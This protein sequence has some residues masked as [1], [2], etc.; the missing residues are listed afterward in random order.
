MPALT[1]QFHYNDTSFG[2]SNDFSKII[3]IL[4][5]QLPFHCHY[6]YGICTNAVLNST[7]LVQHSINNR[8][9][10]EN[11]QIKTVQRFGHTIGAPIEKVR[12]I[13]INLSGQLL[14]SGNW[15]TGKQA[16]ID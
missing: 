11:A 13:V 8:S 5:W 10:A 7:G 12:L 4:P 9:D 2:I 6:L 15:L 16:T 3:K 14:A 1:F